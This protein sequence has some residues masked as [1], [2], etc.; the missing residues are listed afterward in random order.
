MSDQTLQ[1]LFNFSIL[2]SYWESFQKHACMLL[3][4]TTAHNTIFP[5][6]SLSHHVSKGGEGGGKGSC[7]LLACG[8][9]VING[10]QRGETQ[11]MA[12]CD[13]PEG[14]K[15]GKKRRRIKREYVSYP[16]SQTDS[17]GVAYTH[18]KKKIINDPFV[19]VRVG[20]KRNGPTALLDVRGLL[21][22]TVDIVK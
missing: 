12:G 17:P 18:T 19:G 11:D 2:D 15:G 20:K 8:G 4:G 6:P 22:S 9:E 16:H 14:E 10:I 21:Q 7:L 13:L 5:P 1:L 3:A